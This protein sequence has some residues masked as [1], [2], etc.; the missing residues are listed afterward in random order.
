VQL[1]AVN[2]LAEQTGFQVQLLS[3]GTR[4]YRDIAVPVLD[5]AVGVVRLG[6][7]ESRIRQSTASVIRIMS[8]MVVLFLA[9]GI[10]GA[11]IFAHLITRPVAQIIRAA[12]TFDLNKAEVPLLQ[13]ASRDELGILG[14]RFNG[15]MLR[16]REVYAEMRAAQARLIHAEKLTTIGTLA[17]GIAHEVNNPL[18]GLLNCLRRIRKDPGNAAQTTAYI[19]MMMRA[20]DR[21]ETVVRGLLDFARHREMEVHPLA[22]AAVVQD[23]LDLTE[24]R[25]KSSRI[26]VRADLG[27]EIP[28]VPA[29]RHRLGQVFVNLI[30]NA[31]DAMPEGG[32]LTVEANYRV[33]E[34]AGWAEVVIADTGIGI[35]TEVL[36]HIFEPFYTTK[37]QGTGLGLSVSRNIVEEHGGKIAVHSAQGQ[38]TRFT[39]LL[40]AGPPEGRPAAAQ[41]PPSGM[42]APL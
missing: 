35:S 38:G 36:P 14:S 4:L 18:A 17:A 33:A 30:L 26:E 27:A 15:M 37:P 40:P 39:V 8:F 7:L 19:D 20:L 31:A 6:M 3:D 23:A 21:L 25:L 32:R 34:T 2:P 10:A 16:L 12:D 29:D 5:R 11:F 22:L 28:A 41:L 42:D 9:I 13:I 1:L 24:H